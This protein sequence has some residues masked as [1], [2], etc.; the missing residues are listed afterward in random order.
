M[1]HDT[2][3]GGIVIEVMNLISGNKENGI[4]EDVIRF[5]VNKMFPLSGFE[6]DDLIVAMDVW[7]C[8]LCAV[9]V[10]IGV[11]IINGKLGLCG[12]MPI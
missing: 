10:Q 11:Y 6:P 4:V 5:E 7:L 2:G 9:L 8:C 12:F 3:V 1:D